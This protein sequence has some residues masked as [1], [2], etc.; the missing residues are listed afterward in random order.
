MGCGSSTS[1]KV[2]PVESIPPKAPEAHNSTDSAAESKRDSAVDHPNKEEPKESTRKTPEDAKYTVFDVPVVEKPTKP[3]PKRLEKLEGGT[4]L[5]AEQLEEKQKAAEERKQKQ[6][7]QKRSSKRDRLFKD[8]NEAREMEKKSL[9]S[10]L[11]QAEKKREEAQKAIINKRKEHS[12]HVKNVREKAKQL[13]EN[14]TEELNTNWAGEKMEHDN[15]Y[16]ADSE[17]EGWGDD[18]PKEEPQEKSSSDNVD[19]NEQDIFT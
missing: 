14:G 1:A 12:I 9:E 18:S 7:D 16:N 10:R 6:L 17:E 19:E 3:P 2:V 11:A 4:V 15:Q 13:N 5:T 8:I